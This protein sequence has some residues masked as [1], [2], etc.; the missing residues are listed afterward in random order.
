M[1]QLF[2]TVFPHFSELLQPQIYLLHL[3]EFQLIVDFTALLLLLYQITFSKNLKVLGNRLA[4]YVKVFGKGIGCHG[5]HGNQCN[6]R[7]TGGVGYGLENISSHFKQ[8]IGC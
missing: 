3:F 5:L 1:V 4:G 2:K 7:S 6:N 8:L